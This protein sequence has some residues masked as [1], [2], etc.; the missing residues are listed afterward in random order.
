M[1]YVIYGND[2]KRKEEYLD[3]LR[4]KITTPDT[5]VELVEEE[6]V[7]KDWLD[8]SL[9]GR[10]LFGEKKIFLLNDVLGKKEVQ[11]LIFEKIEDFKRT[12]NIFII[13][14]SSFTSKNTDLFKGFAD[15]IKEFSQASGGKAQEFNIFLLGDA[16]GARNKK[17]L[18]VLYER[19]K[20]TGLSDEEIA[21][22][23]FWSVKNL[24]LM[25]NAK[26]GDDAGLNH[27]VASKNRGYVKKYSATEIQKLSGDLIKIYHEA[28][29]GGESMDVALEKFILSL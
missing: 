3:A 21:G 23:L 12:E 7:S 22:T 28:H 29:R 14:E 18:W 13:S 25:K 17:D 10:G 6:Q 19:A 26:E 20:K 16:L 9:Q 1:L 5:S 2:K 27:F 15:E 24:A 8:E 11:E 4:K